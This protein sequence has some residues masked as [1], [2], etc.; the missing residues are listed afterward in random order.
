MQQQVFDLSTD[1]EVSFET[2]FASPAQQWIIDSLQTAIYQKQSDFLTL[3]GSSGSGKSHILKASCLY[4][5][6]LGMTSLYLPI[7]KLM[8]FDP[9]ALLPQLESFYWVC[10]DDIDVIKADAA[11]QS[12]FFYLYNLRK[13]EGKPLIFSLQQPVHHTEFTLLDLKSRLA[14][15]LNLHLPALS[16]DDKIHLLQLRAKQRGMRLTDQCATFIIQR[17]G[18]DLNALMTVVDQLDVATLAAGRKITIPFIKA[19]LGW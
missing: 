17:S 1:A 14:A 4:A 19:Q 5:H 3:T 8:D 7:K 13:E 12:M 2:F 18:R 15:C 10:V 6:Q 11:W 16:D 9:N